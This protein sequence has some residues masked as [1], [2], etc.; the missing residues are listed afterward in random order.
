MGAHT[1]A[2]KA[3]VSAGFTRPT[4]MNPALGVCAIPG[5]DGA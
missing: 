4:P 5:A 3:H 2:S 1:F